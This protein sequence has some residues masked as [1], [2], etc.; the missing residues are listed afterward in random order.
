MKYTLYILAILF[1]CFSLQSCSEEDKDALMVGVW[2]L[3]EISENGEVQELTKAEQNTKMLI[4]SNGVYRLNQKNNLTAGDIY[5][6]AWSVTDNKWVELSSESWKLTLN[7]LSSTTVSDQW[8][9]L[10]LPYRFSILKLNEQELEIRIRAFIGDIK[11]CALFTEP[12]IPL[13]TKE[14]LSEIQS[15]F[16]TL[17]TYIFKFKK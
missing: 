7:P 9:R 11:Y 14:N 2:Q 10:H 3:T 5:F 1:F 15:E 6:G 4:E 8:V 12:T 17:R 16:K 13:L